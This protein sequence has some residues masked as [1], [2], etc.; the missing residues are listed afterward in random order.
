MEGCGG[1]TMRKPRNEHLGSHTIPGCCLCHDS[2]Y[3][4]ATAGSYLTIRTE[5][6]TIYIGDRL[7]LSEFSIDYP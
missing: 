7:V 6:L 2:V 5:C 3:V 1:D 4:M